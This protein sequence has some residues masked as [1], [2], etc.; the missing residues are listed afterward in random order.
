MFH[1]AENDIQISMIN[2]DWFKAKDRVDL[3]FVYQVLR[4]VDV[5]EGCYF[6][7]EDAVF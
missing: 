6:L 5:A 2:L 4:R 3:D 7:S 1:L